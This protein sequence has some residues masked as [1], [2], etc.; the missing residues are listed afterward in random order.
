MLWTNFMNK[1]IASIL[2]RIDI[3]LWNET[4]HYNTILFQLDISEYLVNHFYKRIF[5]H[6]I[7]QKINY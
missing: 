6:T 2:N 3:D 1:T 5:Y 4:L 7:S